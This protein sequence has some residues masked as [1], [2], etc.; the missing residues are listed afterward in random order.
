[1]TPSTNLERRLTEYYATEPPLRAPDR[2][3]LST[4]VTIDTTPQRRGLL[5][6]WRNPELSS[7][8]KLAGAAAVLIAVFGVALWQLAPPSPGGQPTPHPS[9]TPVTTFSPSPTRP[10]PTAYVMPALT[11]T[12]T[13]D[14]YGL[15]VSYPQGWETHAAKETWT[16]GE[17]PRFGDPAGDFMFDTTLQDHLFVA[18]G[19]QP[20]AGTRLDQWL[21]DFLS[22]E[23]CM[24]S[25]P[26]EVDGRDGFMF[27]DC[28]VALVQSDG[29]GYIVGIWASDDDPQVRGLNTRLLLEQILRTVQLHPEDAVE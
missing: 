24:V 13:S 25:G 11:G 3:L 5:A 27:R 17:L 18:V 12:F 10:G 19:S 23:G 20:L 2:V 29:R 9:A 26:V 4:L 28:D 15:S 21:R 14:L 8:T 22:D 7:Y 1:M 16:G 6:P